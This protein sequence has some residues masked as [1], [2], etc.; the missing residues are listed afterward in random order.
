MS[1]FKITIQD[2]YRVIDF[3]VSS[4]SVTNVLLKV[5]NEL[6]DMD[7]KLPWKK[8]TVEKNYLSNSSTMSQDPESE[9]PVEEVAAPVEEAPAE[10]AA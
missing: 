10:P 8:F 6:K 1:A 2:D 9:A 4:K 5:A 7:R 3:E